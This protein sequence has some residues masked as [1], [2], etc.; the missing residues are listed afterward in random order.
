MS[1][2]EIFSAAVLLILVI[3]PFGNVPLV[4]SAMKNVPP[5]RRA[6]VV[7]RE[8]I[9]AYVILVGAHRLQALLGERVVL[10][11][12]RLMGLVLTALAVEMLLGGVRTF[13]THIA[14]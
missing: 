12:E 4:V 8:C 14:R 9:A 13:V 6:W 11:F 10:A 1:G 5:A 2:N 7:L 3:D